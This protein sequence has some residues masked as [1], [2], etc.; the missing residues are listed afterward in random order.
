MSIVGARI[1]RR[2]DP[3]LITGAAPYVDDITLPAMGYA[4]F[5]R[6]PHAH[7]RVTGIDVSQAAADPRIIAVLTGEEAAHLA[8][9][10]PVYT[11]LPA[12]DI[13]QPKQHC[14]AYPLVRY[15]GEAVAVVAAS[16]RY[17]AE[18]AVEQVQVAY[19]PLPALMDAEQALSADAVRLHEELGTNVGLTLTREGGDVERAFAEAEVVLRKR[20]RFHRHTGSPIE[21]RGIIASYLPV[22][23][24]LTV[25]ASTQIPHI[26]RSHLSQ[27][28]NFP[29]ER[30][31]VIAP[32]VG[33]G[34]GNKL[35]VA[36]EYV[37]VCLLAIKSGRPI[38]WIE[39]RQESLMAFVHARDQMHDVE[40]AARR[41]GTLL[42]IRDRILVDAGAYLDARISGPSLGAALW[43]VGPYKMRAFRAD[44]TVVMTNKCPYGAYRGFGSNKGVMVIERAVDLLARELRLD[45]VEVR[46]R[47]LIQPSEL[48]YRTV[49]DLEYDSGDYPAALDK[50]LAMVDYPRLRE[51]QARLRRQGRYIG[52]GVAMAVEGAGW[53]TYTAA[54]TTPFVQTRDFASPTIRMLL[55]GKVNVLIGSSAIGT[56][57]ATTVSQIV[58]QELGLP[59]EDIEVIEGDTAITPYDTG[60]RA[61]RFAAVVFP[62]LHLT[63]ARLRE[64]LLAIAAGMLEADPR[65][66]ELGDRCVR[67]KG[68]PA[69]SVPFDRIAH[70]AYAEVGK[71][72]PG[73][74]AGLE[75]TECFIAPPNSICITWPYAVHVPVVEVDVETGQVKFLRYAIVHD[76][77]VQANPMVVEG[78]MMGGTAQGIGGMIYEELV[79]DEHGQLLT[80]TFMDYLLPTALEIPNFDIAHMHT[81][82]PLIPGG[83]KGMGEG[84]AVYSYPA[85]FNAVADAIE[86][87]GTEVLTTPLSPA[88]IQ[89]LLRHARAPRTAEPSPR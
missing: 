59:V 53:N 83:Y 67:V 78:Q 33:G 47:N 20:F 68:T 1:R 23:G 37:A 34:F 29:E 39:T 89:R 45:P 65:D 87:L 10:M 24:E 58:A 32:N 70:V 35:Q 48:P 11:Y 73:M 44:V 77:G 12:K 52:I 17:L 9:P 75:A 21:P 82:S 81:P 88:N 61:A 15:A 27:I 5:V 7:A 28:L 71:L 31:R 76:C 43:I 74:P 22:T 86:C 3:K 85:V 30:I 84:G 18:D 66:L 26:L 69:K 2:E 16:E 42:A 40:L 56:S 63:T 80:S 79:Y 64:K 36:P 55:S 46:R 62:A 13:R 14:L 25:W 60:T 54:M 51:E 72:P 6:S 8:K 57:H 50:A 49:S 41:D 38:K 19:D 4:A